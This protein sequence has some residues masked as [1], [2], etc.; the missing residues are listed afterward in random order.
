MPKKKR[1]VET[2]RVVRSTGIKIPVEPDQNSRKQEQFDRLLA[3]AEHRQQ[4][5]WIMASVFHVKIPDQPRI[6]MDTEN[7]M[8]IE[9]PGCYICEQ[10][11][12][13][14]IDPVCPGNA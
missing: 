13:P 1:H 6:H 8:T 10:V 9:G 11:Y 2:R 5:F 12:E 4:H 14:G 7:L 3:I